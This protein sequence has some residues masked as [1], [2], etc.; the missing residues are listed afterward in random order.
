L[1]DFKTKELPHVNEPN[2]LCVRARE[3]EREAI[4]QETLLHARTKD[5]EILPRIRR[6]IPRLLNR[7]LLFLK[8]SEHGKKTVVYSC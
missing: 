7:L 3:R 1:I 8:M 4:L 6:V 2:A 5:T